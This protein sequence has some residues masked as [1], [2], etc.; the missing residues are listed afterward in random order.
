[1]KFTNKYDQAL[2]YEIFQKEE[3]QLLKSHLVQAKEIIDI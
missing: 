2:Y 3:Y 1:M